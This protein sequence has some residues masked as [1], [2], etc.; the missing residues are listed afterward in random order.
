MIFFIAERVYS[1]SP[2]TRNADWRGD[3]LLDPLKVDMPLT[4]G[5]SPWLVTLIFSGACVGSSE[6]ALDGA[7]IHKKLS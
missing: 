1:L 2:H 4:M 6:G 3:P 7:E 5:Q